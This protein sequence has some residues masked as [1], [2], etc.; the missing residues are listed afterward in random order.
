MKSMAVR[1]PSIDNNIEELSKF[2]EY[3][4]E[5][6]NSPRR[7]KLFPWPHPNKACGIGL[8][9]IMQDLT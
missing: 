4:V 5:V 8:I 9:L 2:R 1:W 6:R 3:C 7:I